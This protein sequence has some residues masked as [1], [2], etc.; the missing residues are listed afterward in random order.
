MS[1]TLLWHPRVIDGWTAWCYYS[2]RLTL[3]A[4]DFILCCTFCW[5]GAQWLWIWS[6]TVESFFFFL[7]FFSF[8]WSWKELLRNDFSV[9]PVIVLIMLWYSFL[10]IFHPH[11]LIFHNNGA[12]PLFC[13]RSIIFWSVQKSHES[14]GRVWASV[15]RL[16]EEVW[17]HG[18]T[19][20]Q[21]F[22][23]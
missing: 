1:G 6:K 3:S 2:D 15:R 23:C 22:P 14:A 12:K 11:S 7:F 4:S 10:L 13:Y 20:L 9:P 18:A 19:G 8:T 5:T 16:I 17:K 21:P